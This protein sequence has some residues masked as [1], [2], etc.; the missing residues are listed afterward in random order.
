MRR[1]HVT[2]PEVYGPLAAYRRT[3]IVE[4]YIGKSIEHR[5]DSA[6][7]SSGRSEFGVKLL[8]EQRHHCR[9][10]VHLTRAE[11]PAAVRINKNKV[12]TLSHC[13]MECSWSTF[14]AAPFQ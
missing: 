1:Q 5:K 8:V 13:T 11:K 7:P 12:C 4:R 10:V 9:D 6:M 2:S 3:D 14:I